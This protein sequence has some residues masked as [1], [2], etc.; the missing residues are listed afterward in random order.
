MKT[1]FLILFI[2]VLGLGTAQ[3]TAVNP[4]L[5]PLTNGQSI[6][7][8][9]ALRPNA[10]IAE[11]DTA[12]LNLQVYKIKRNAQRA[13]VS[14]LL[15]VGALFILLIGIATLSVGLVLLGLLA[16]LALGILSTIWILVG[17]VQ[18]SEF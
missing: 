14:T 15:Q 18:L 8:P 7:K 11:A 16:A 2:G 13:L 10:V 3:A 6:A 17:L 4:D 5:H 9:L 12:L 1:F